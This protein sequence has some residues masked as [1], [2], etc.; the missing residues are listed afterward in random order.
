[1]TRTSLL[2]VILL[3]ILLLNGADALMTLAVVRRG[4]AVEANPIMA[5]LLDHGDVPFL[6]A[7]AGLVTVGVAV[8]WAFRQRPLSLVGAGVACGTYVLVLVQHL[9][10][11]HA[12]SEQLVR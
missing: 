8:L 11:A 12:V 3:A 9:R 1:M 7:K 10:V 2:R 5:A 6:L 4:H